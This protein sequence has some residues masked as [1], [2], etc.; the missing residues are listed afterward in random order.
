MN[1]I[2]PATPLSSSDNSPRFIIALSPGYDVPSFKL[3][4]W[5]MAELTERL[6]P[7]FAPQNPVLLR[8]FL[9]DRIIGYATKE[10]LSGA[11]K[12]VVAELNRPLKVDVFPC[13]A[14]MT[15]EELD[16]ASLESFNNAENDFLSAKE[17]GEALDMEGFVQWYGYDQPSQSGDKPNSRKGMVC[18]VGNTT[19]PNALSLSEQS[20]IAF[21][22]GQWFVSDGNTANIA[23]HG[24]FPS[25][26]V[27]M[28]FGRSQYHATR[29]TQVDLSRFS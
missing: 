24:P 4:G 21:E 26:D 14:P 9:H 1:P 12:K 11:L 22:V 25:Q 18:V 2:S 28:R 29:F 15:K 13:N 20:G 8:L 6:A 10:A 23:I 5:L 16:A 19:P 17:I 3:H 7:P 27:A